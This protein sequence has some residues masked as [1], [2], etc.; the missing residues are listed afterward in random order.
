SAYT[1]SYATPGEFVD[2]IIGSW[3][4]ESGSRIPGS[5][6]PGEIRVLTIGVLV[7]LVL[8]DVPFPV[9]REGCSGP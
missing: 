6:R 1:Y 9:P 8:G 2:W 3:C 7:R 4:F 5:L